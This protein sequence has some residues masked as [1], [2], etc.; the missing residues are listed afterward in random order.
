ML[1]AFPFDLRR[2]HKTQ[3]VIVEL[4]CRLKQSLEPSDPR[5]LNCER[6][7]KVVFIEK[8]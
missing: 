7:E 3:R 6:I 1:I 4:S 8:L 5:Q 2:P